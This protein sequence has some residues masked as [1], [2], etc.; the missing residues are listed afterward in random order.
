MDPGSTRLSVGLVIGHAGGTGNR[1]T[2]RKSAVSEK[3][4]CL[5]LG[6]YLLHGESAVDYADDVGG[7]V[8]L[9]FWIHGVVS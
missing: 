1:Y 3:L 5:R 2:A 9:S 6:V 4:H 7:V 8:L